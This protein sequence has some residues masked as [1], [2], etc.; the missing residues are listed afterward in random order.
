MAQEKSSATATV[1][2]ATDA[3]RAEASELAGTAKDEARDVM[4]QARDQAKSTARQVQDDVRERANNE[5]SK[6]AQT[7]HDASRQ[8]R[9]MADAGSSDQPSLPANLVREGAQATD[10]LASRIEDGGVDAVLAQVRTWARQNPGG[11]LLGATVA[12]FVAGRLARNM[13][14]D[15]T[16]GIG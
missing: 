13:S 7:L 9:T 3:T 4:Q 10:R 1:E 14:G 8:M 5:A 11:F 2:Q 16:G 12:G 15:G 6:F